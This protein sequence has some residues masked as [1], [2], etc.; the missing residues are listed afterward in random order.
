M[1]NN[2]LIKENISQPTIIQTNNACF[3]DISYS[4]MEYVN[5]GVNKW[6][7]INYIHD[8][9]KLQTNVG[10][11][12]KTI[13]NKCKLIQTQSLTNLPTRFDE[14]I[15][16]SEDNINIM[17]GCEFNDYRNPVSGA[18]CLETMQNIDDYDRVI[19]MSNFEKGYLIAFTV[20]VVG[21]LYKANNRLMS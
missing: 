1:G 15:K 8:F 10:L 21:I 20:L 19:V 4:Q 16:L 7:G 3:N 12:E 13:E 5:T 2:L 11:E 6:V 14:S 18:Y 9:I 17:S